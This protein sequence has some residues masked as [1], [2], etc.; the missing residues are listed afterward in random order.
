MQRT[1]PPLWGTGRGWLGRGGTAVP[2]GMTLSPQA[3]ERE[4]SSLRRAKSPPVNAS[5]LQDGPRQL[6]Q[7]AHGIALDA[8]EARRPAIALDRHA[9]GDGR[10]LRQYA[11]KRGIA[12]VCREVDEV[13]AIAVCIDESGQGDERQVVAVEG[14]G[15]EQRIARRHLEGPEIGEFDEKPVLVVERGSG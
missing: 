1:P 14:M 13:V 5:F 4:S 3:E 2:N 8:A 10:S 15:D 9:L 6:L 7:P 12:P 11:V